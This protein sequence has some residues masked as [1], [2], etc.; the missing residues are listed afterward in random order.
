M[1][2]QAGDRVGPDAEATMKL[3][4]RHVIA[5]LRSMGLLRG[6]RGLGLEATEVLFI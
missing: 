5:V 4:G 6:N 1:D 3:H 2:G